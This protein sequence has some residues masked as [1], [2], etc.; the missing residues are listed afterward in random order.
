MERLRECCNSQYCGC[1]CSGVDSGAQCWGTRAPG[2]RKGAKPDFYFSEFQLLQ[3]APLDL[4]SYL[5]LCIVNIQATVSQC[6]VT[7]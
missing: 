1:H 7:N 2:F 5:Q 3:Q 6:Y 4:K